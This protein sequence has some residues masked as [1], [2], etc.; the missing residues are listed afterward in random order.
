MVKVYTPSDA[1]LNVV[2]YTS[3]E[4]A[5]TTGVKVAALLGI[6]DFTTTTSPTKAE[7][8]DI[9][10]RSE[11]YI[12]EI[13]NSSW[14]ENLVENEFHD[15]QWTAALKTVWDD[16]RGKIRLHNEYLRK[17]IRIA[18]WEGDVYK[19]IASAV[20]TVTL[21][22]YTNV[23]NVTLSI[24]GLTWTLTAGT[25]VGEFNKTFGKRTTAQE[26]CY[27]I[28]ESPPT[29]TAQFTGATASKV[30]QDGSTTHNISNFFYANLEEDDSVTVVSLLPGSDG[31]N[32]T[33]TVSGSGISKSDFTDKETYDRNGTWWDMKDTGDVFFRTEYPYHSKHSIKV[34]YSY[35]D[36][37]VPAIIEDAAT[38]LVCCEL[39]ASDDSYVLLGDDSTSGLDLKTRYDTYKADVDKILK[40]KKRMIYY[41]DGD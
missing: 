13:T 35:G 30:L 4:G 6:S 18:I 2:N 7:I 19:D 1:P 33:I 39:I 24:G 31:S 5:Y 27:L 22:D 40:L 16:Y 11:D 25:A 17:I 26:L 9:I 12:D 34:T 14:R 32:C 10:R 41:L 21:S 37:R 20:A 23:T 3:A 8:G 36:I 29:M 28:N 15:F 38:K